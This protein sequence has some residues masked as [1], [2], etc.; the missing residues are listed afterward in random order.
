MGKVDE[1]AP[2]ITVN[3]AVYNQLANLKLILEALSQQTYKDFEISITDDGSSDGTKEE[4][5]GVTEYKGIPLRYQ[6]QED[7]GFRL[8][9]SKN[10]GIDKARGKYF[11]SLEGDVIPNKRLLEQYA[12]DMKE[13]GV[14]YG[15]RHQVLEFPKELDFAQLDRA[16]VEPDWRME[17]LKRLYATSKPWLLCSGCNFIMPT[18][19]LREVGKWDEEFQSYGGDDVDV[20]LRLFAGGCDIG[21]NIDAYGYHLKHKEREEI[22]EHR[23]KIGKREKEY[24]LA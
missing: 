16:I 23:D 13:D 9:K 21:A 19:K 18:E 24:N 4:F 6:W 20:A 8:A 7:I 12:K 14:I 15:V 10:M 11:L 17:Q 22:Q 1:K 5:D 3:V 2:E